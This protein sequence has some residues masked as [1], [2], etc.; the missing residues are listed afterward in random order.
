MNRWT[1]IGHV[2]RDPERRATG[3][4]TGI[5]LNVDRRQHAGGDG[6]DGYFD[7]KVFEGQGRACASPC[8]PAA[9]ERCARGRAGCHGDP[10]ELIEAASNCCSKSCSGAP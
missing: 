8:R 1:G 6:V 3:G 4:G 10:R 9:R 5:W 2:T 7:V